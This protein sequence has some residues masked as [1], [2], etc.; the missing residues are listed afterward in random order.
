MLKS[1]LWLCFLWIHCRK[2]KPTC[3]HMTPMPQHLSNICC[4]S[5][6]YRRYHSQQ[7]T[8][9]QHAI[10]EQTNKG[11]YVGCWNILYNWFMN[12]NL[13]ALKFVIFAFKIIKP[14]LATAKLRL[15]ASMMSICLSVCLT[16]CLSAKCKNAIFSKSKQFR[17]IVSIDDDYE[18]VH[19]LFKEPIIGPLKSTMVD[20]C[21]LG[22]WLQNAKTRFSG[23]WA[24]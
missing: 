4:R 8:L 13:I 9:L 14:Q 2:L 10:N 11:V 15:H 20:L 18:V 6:P 23:N 1:R 22:S 24:I 19:G 3:G 21:H 7:I 12:E 16:V 17:G 5:F